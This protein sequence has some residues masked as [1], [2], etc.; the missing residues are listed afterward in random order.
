M[1]DFEGF[2]ASKVER[3]LGRQL[4]ALCDEGTDRLLRLRIGT[5]KQRGTSLMNRKIPA[6]SEAEYILWI[7]E[8][9]ATELNSKANA[10]RR[11]GMDLR[12]LESRWA[13]ELI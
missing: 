13:G 6:M 2:I 3:F 4:C 10:V 5:P 8:W 12:S 9:L 7:T 11:S 1:M